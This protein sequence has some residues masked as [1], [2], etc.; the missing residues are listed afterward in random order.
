MSSNKDEEEAM[1]EGEWGRDDIY[2]QYDHIEE[3][4]RDQILGEQEDD[5]LDLAFQETFRLA[6]HAIQPWWT[7]EYRE[8]STNLINK[9]ESYYKQEIK[10]NLCHQ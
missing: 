6:H 10:D 5:E 3:I 7:V 4:T 9:A 8:K 2:D 1:R